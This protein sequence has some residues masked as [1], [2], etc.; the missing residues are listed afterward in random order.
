VSNFF[1]F[2]LLPNGA[3]DST[4]IDEFSVTNFTDD[5]DGDITFNLGILLNP[6]GKLSAGFIYKEGGSYEVSQFTSIVNRLVVPR[7]G[8]SLNPAPAEF[9]Q[10]FKVELPDVLNLGFAY[11]PTDE[12]LLALDV[13]HVR[14]SDLPPLSGFSLLAGIPAAGSVVLPGPPGGRP[15]V[16]GPRLGDENTY[17]LGV[18]RVFIFEAPVMSMQTL[19]LRAGTFNENGSGGYTD[20]DR[21]DQHWT[22]GLGTNF[23][24]RVQVDLAAEFSDDVDNI[25]LSGIYRF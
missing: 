18:E 5:E 24:E 19:A 10:R 3:I 22:V 21:E 13:H 25:V 12:W 2:E 23:G 6:G 17:H 15:R 16:A 7:L 4:V 1:D 8:I 14:Y 20:L 9:R 11:R